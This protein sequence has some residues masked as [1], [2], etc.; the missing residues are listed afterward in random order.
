MSGKERRVGL[1]VT[2][3]VDLLRPE[4]GFASVRLLEMA[5]CT[6]V[7]PSAQTCCGQP[8]W[9][10]GADGHA[11]VLARQ[12]IDA[13]AGLDYVVA[14]SGSC[15]GTIKRHYPAMLADDAAYAARA[16][17][18][19][20]RT[21][22]LSAFLVRICGMNDLAAKANTKI[23]YHDSCSSLRDLGVRSEPRALLAQIAG[24]E[25]CELSDG[26]V[27]CG[28]GGMFSAKYPE[29]STHMADN[30]LADVNGTGAE[31]L[32][33]NDLGCLMHLEARAK[34][35]KRNLRVRHIAEFLCEAMPEPDTGKA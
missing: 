17:D 5:G 7:V 8:A 9:N 3:L 34:H 24:T 28:F 19:A 27:C 29:I 23:T 33:G 26:E 32:V 13:F 16:R 11:R 18:L 30:K 1:F 20:D 6:V 12:T 21:Y 10:A 31:T 4:I 2:C 15:A 25:L 35:Q 14:P 22:E